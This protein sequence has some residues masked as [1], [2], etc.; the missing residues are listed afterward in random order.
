MKT[1]FG[2]AGFR[3][4]CLAVLTPLIATAQTGT[5][6]S[7]TD[8]EKTVDAARQEGTVVVSVPTSAELRKQVEAAFH[9]RFNGIRLEL[10]A[11]RGSANV[12][13]IIEEKKAG[14]HY[15]DLHVGGTSSIVTGLLRA[16][17]LEPVLPW[18]ILPEVKDPK[19]W[20][21]GHVWADN[22]QKYIY[23]FLGYM[24]ETIWYN[25]DLVRPEEVVTYDDLLQP[26]WK[27]KMV[28]LDPRT[29][30]S[31]ESMW[32]FLW[33]IKGE[34]YLQK[35]AAQEMLLGRNLRQLAETVARGK[36]ALSIGVSYYSYLPFIKVGLPIRPLPVVKEGIY[37]S[38]GSGSLVILKNA[39]HPNATKVF[40]N[41]LL[42]KEGQTTFTKAMGQPTRRYDVDTRWTREFGHIAGKETLTPAK[43]HELENQSEEVVVK[44]R[45]P[46]SEL[47]RK[48]FKE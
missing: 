27:G 3:L 33:R 21:A 1:I 38:S 4:F 19:N 23:V 39:P 10:V 18:M 13:R 25:S 45:E 43:F 7:Q 41:W 34:E 11:A 26:K 16:D 20:W 22:A 2:I 12:N 24:T 44:F 48:F 17:L 14:V 46:A 5:S 32:A 6:S 35:L 36:A 29:P 9:Q 30:G 40:V 31:G 37:A 8:W 28:M 42:S 15:F 47:A